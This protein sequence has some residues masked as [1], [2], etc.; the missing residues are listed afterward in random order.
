MC[1][2]CWQNLCSWRLKWLI[3]GYV[4]RARAKIEWN[5]G[6]LY[7]LDCSV[8]E[9]IRHFFRNRNLFSK[10]DGDI[11][12]TEASNIRFGSLTINLS[13]NKIVAF[14]YPSLVKLTK[15]LKNYW[16]LMR[17]VKPQVPLVFVGMKDNSLWL[18]IDYKKLYKYK[19][20]KKC[21]VHIW[22][23]F[24]TYVNFH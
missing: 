16:R 2:K 24:V 14:P 3:S 6:W 22:S 17:Y 18:C 8:K 1:R 15:I 4:I 12:C 9:L 21:N 10:D 20:R 7:R 5:T 13:F 19:M 11:S 23:E